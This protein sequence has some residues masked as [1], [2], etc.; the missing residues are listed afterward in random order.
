QDES[1]TG[2]QDPLNLL[3][4]QVDQLNTQD[5]LLMTPDPL[6]DSIDDIM[7]FGTQ[8]AIDA[9]VFGSQQSQADTVD[10]AVENESTQSTQ[11]TQPTQLT[12]ADGGDALSSLPTLVRKALFYG[13]G[14]GAE[15]VDD[16]SISGT[17]LPADISASISIDI[18]ADMPANV[19]DDVQRLS[20]MSDHE[21]AVEATSSLPK[22]TSG[23]RR[24]LRRHNHHDRNK[25]SKLSKTKKQAIRTEFVE[26][27]AEEGESSD[28]DNESGVRHGKFNWG[29]APPTSK[30]DDDDDDDEL[31]MDTDEEEAALLADPMINNDVAEDRKADQAIRDLHRQQDLDQDEQDIQDLVKDINT[32]RLRNRTNGS[33]TGFALAEE[34]YIDRQTRAERMEERLRQR[35]KLQAREIHDTNLA[36]IAKNPETAA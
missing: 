24:F 21:E 13:Q 27:E 8:L 17:P 26:A 30:P 31:D 7:G 1:I 10:R 14:G 5:S 11:P 33:R 36:E 28:S 35:R 16:V 34:D 25:K 20:D 4:S 3:S 2:S 12:A 15:H 22:A 19:P 9:H 32:G 6:P 18:P 29:D 23:G